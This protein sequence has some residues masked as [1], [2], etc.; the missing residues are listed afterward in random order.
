MTAVDTA[1]EAVAAAIREL[2]ARR[3]PVAQAAADARARL[4]EIDGER[5]RLC[6]AYLAL[7]GESVPAP[8]PPVEA[9]DDTVGLSGRDLL[10]AV[11]APPS[12]Q[13]GLSRQ[14]VA[15]LRDLA[16]GRGRPREIAGR[17]G[18]TTGA[19]QQ[20][21]AALGKKGL[22]RRV[23]PGVYELTPL[24]EGTVLPAPTASPG[25]E[26]AAPPPPP[27]T[28]V[29]A[30]T[31]A[32]RPATGRSGSPAGARDRILDALDGRPD[33]AD[34]P[35]VAELA[36]MSV[37]GATIALRDLER[38]RLVVRRAGRWHPA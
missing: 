6:D 25:A 20:Q 28:A 24:G 35:L 9:V 13:P 16:A 10:E 23:E 12:T 7:T 21:M 26:Q 22:V 34:T 37:A 32:P 29:D 38:E 11:T 2:D 5:V 19:V 27:P 33:G 36:G 30:A 17:V 18:S 8:R 31:E 3:A 15:V 14:A 4:D 1:A